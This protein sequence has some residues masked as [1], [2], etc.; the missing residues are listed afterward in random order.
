MGLELTDRPIQDGVSPQRGGR[1]TGWRRR[2]RRLL[3][4]S[5]R[6]MERTDNPRNRRDNRYALPQ[7]LKKWN[8]P[9]VARP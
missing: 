8:L 3:A 4:E 2:R 9:C 1:L 6:H 5:R 7:P